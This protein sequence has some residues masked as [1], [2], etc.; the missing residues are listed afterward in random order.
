MSGLEGRPQR[1]RR[2]SG[3]NAAPAARPAA[4]GGSA[5]ASPQGSGPS[6]PQG[7]GGTAESEERPTREGAP[8]GEGGARA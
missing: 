8:G 4:G 5:R 1:E 2:G 3:D 7:D 6:P